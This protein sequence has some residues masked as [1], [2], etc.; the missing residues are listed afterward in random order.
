MG[1]DFLMSKKKSKKKS[2]KNSN[3]P[4]QDKLAK[5]FNSSF[6]DNNGVRALVIALAAAIV[7]QLLEA[8]AKQ[9]KSSNGENAGLS[10]LG[11][12]IKDAAIAFQGLANGNTPVAETVGTVK[13]A[14]A[15][16]KPVVAGMVPVVQGVVS[17]LK[18]QATTSKA[19]P[20]QESRTAAREDD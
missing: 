2:E 12:A 19:P 11:D 5:K 7:E 3:K 9:G 17:V 16:I 1:K 10:K 18:D 14:I 13:D 8:I 6:L 15:D 4:V 20:A